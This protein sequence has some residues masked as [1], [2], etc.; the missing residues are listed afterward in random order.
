[1]EVSM[2]PLSLFLFAVIAFAVGAVHLVLAIASN[3]SAEISG[4]WFFLGM[5]A[6]WTGS[7]LGVQQRRL[8]DLEDEVA[9]LRPGIAAEREVAPERR[10]ES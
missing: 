7:V 9:R 4:P 5:L 2:S 3:R 8:R 10:P 1:M 6:S